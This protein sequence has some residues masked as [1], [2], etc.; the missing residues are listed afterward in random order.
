MIG[1]RGF[2]D[3]CLTLSQLEISHAFKFF[4]VWDGHPD[5]TEAPVSR[6]KYL[7]VMVSVLKLG[8]F[9]GY[10]FCLRFG[11]GLRHEGFVA[12]TNGT[13]TK[14]KAKS[15]RL[16]PTIKSRRR[17]WGS[18][19]CNIQD[20]MYNIYIYIYIYYEHRIGVWA[21]GFNV[22]RYLEFRVCQYFLGLDFW[23]S[24]AVRLTA[25]DI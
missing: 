6:R 18:V 24:G 25:E 15:F 8:G 4:G 12:Y 16:R 5:P 1:K 19:K 3:N 22:W 7:L 13:N 20:I 23:F 10:G 11:A 9:R 14:P 21:F 2:G 17:S